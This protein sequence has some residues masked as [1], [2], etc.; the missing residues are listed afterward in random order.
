[1]SFIN[2][3]FLFAASAALLPILYHLIRKSRARKVKFSSLLFLRATPKALIKKRRL[4]DLLLLIIR[5]CILGFLAFMFARPFI[6]REEIPIVSLIADRSM[7]IL[8]DNSYSMQ[9]DNLFE[10]AKNEAVNIIENAG[11]ADEFAVV[12]F[13]DNPQQISE[14]NNN[15]VLQKQLL[16]NMV[17]AS[18]TATDLYKPIRLAEEILLDARH[19]E[20]VII[21]ISDFQSNGWSSQFENWNLEQGI[22]FIP[23]KITHESLSNQYINKLSVLQK[24]TGETT[25]VQ[26]GLQI[27]AEGNIPARDTGVSLW[28]NGR[29]A[30]RKTTETSKSHQVYFQQTGLREGVYQGFTK[31]DDDNLNVDN[32][33]YFSFSI[34]KRPSILCIENSPQSFRSNTFFLKNCFALG[35]QAQ[36]DFSSS[37]TRGLTDAVLRNHRVVFLANVGSLTNQQ[38]RTLK[39]YVEQGGSVIISFGGETNPETFSRNLSELGIGSLDG[40]VEARTSAAI[41]GEVDFRHP[42]FS[43]FAQ[44]GTGDISRP[45]FREY[46]KVIPDSGAVVIGKYNT[47]DAFLIERNIGK[48][49]VIVCTST[50]NTEWGD[51]PINEIY[52]PFIYQLVKYSLSSSETE[53]S[54][55]VGSPV[56]LTGMP[57]DEWEVKT[58]DNKIIK[59]AIDKTGTSYF[60]ETVIPG[61]YQATHNGKQ[62]FF[63]VNVETR[64]SELASKDEKEVISAVTP[65]PDEAEKTEKLASLRNIVEEE[66]TQKFWRYIL[67]FIML[68]FLFETYFAN[69]KVGIFQI[70]TKTV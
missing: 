38:M 11:S 55:V 15:R 14:L 54:Y 58:P 70:K 34:E 9:Y 36:Y 52:L 62:R 48:G 8:L 24:L 37:G 20:R 16:M 50:L 18:Y 53:N 32:Y 35:E 42:V 5:S 67:F 63:S 3:I 30:D 17:S 25:S 47:N 69:R 7:V 21:M 60:Y 29:E 1:M 57:G 6:P 27:N 40:K 12:V 39:S 56:V 61:N 41:I 49:K 65:P 31:L 46:M 23:Q 33:K 2:P 19:Q 66:K 51:F 28:I 44:S 64:E 68:L 22:T 13:S 10:E 59:T 26:L 43:A 45:G 4:Q